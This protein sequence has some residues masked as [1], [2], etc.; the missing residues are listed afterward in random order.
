MLQDST[1]SNELRCTYE[2]YRQ[3]IL[4]TTYI[5]AYI[6]SIRNLVQH[7]QARHFQE[8]PIL[9]I[10]GQSPEI[11]DMATTYNA[12]LDTLK[13]WIAIRLQWLDANIPGLCV[14]NTSGVTV[15]NSPGVLHYFPNP[16]NGTFHFEGLING[17]IS[18]Q[19]IVYDI[20]GKMIDRIEVQAG[21]IKFDYT[22]DRKG[23]Y[24]FSISNKNKIMQ[25]GKLI[26]M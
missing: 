3:N 6:D 16:G 7:A 1:F 25:H 12:E 11:G 10:G 2:N 9:E 5:F 8:W 14:P 19:M 4:D 23:I 18:S 13:K 15:A 20:A 26:V 22:L 17:E 24:F 21:H